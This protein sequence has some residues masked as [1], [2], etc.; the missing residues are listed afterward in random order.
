MKCAENA[1]GVS[2]FKQAMSKAGIVALVGWQGAVYSDQLKAAYKEALTIFY[3]EGG[4]VAEV[5]LRFE[6]AE[7]LFAEL[8]TWAGKEFPDLLLLA[9]TVDNVQKF[10]QVIEIYE[11]ARMIDRAVGVG[12]GIIPSILRANSERKDPIAFLY[13]V[14]NVGS[15]E[16]LFD[17][18]I[19]TQKFYPLEVKDQVFIDGQWTEQKRLQ[20]GTI[21]QIMAVAP[22]GV[23]YM[24]TG[25]LNEGSCK[26][27]AA[28]K[29]VIG[30]GASAV[31]ASLKKEQFSDDTFKEI[32]RVSKSMIEAF[33]NAS[34]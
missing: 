14:D 19:L 13:G 16:A 3:E 2:V 30:G 5:L 20:L 12:P 7:V 29:G 27:V 21:A 18:G 24:T 34:A 11:D 15:A 1:P 31:F 33:A 6:K 8:L 32:R 17:L 23:S 28:T 4:R 22:D 9:G 26:V 10:E 25:G